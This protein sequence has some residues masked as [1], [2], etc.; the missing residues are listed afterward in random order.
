MDEYVERKGKLVFRV[1][2]LNNPVKIKVDCQYGTLA[3]VSFYY[4]GLKT[5]KCGEE[6]LIGKG[7]DL[8][9]Q[10]LEFSGASGNPDGGRLKIIHTI[11]E[12][13]GNFVVYTFPDEYTGKPPFDLK[14]QEPSYVFTVNFI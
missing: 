10:S 6:V 1:S 9:N 11:Y 8:K 4:Y 3:G 2:G 14:D 5:V 13:G 7:Q 12:I